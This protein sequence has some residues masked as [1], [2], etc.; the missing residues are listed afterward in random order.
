[1]DV[2]ECGH[3]ATWPAPARLCPHLVQ[4]RGSDHKPDFVRLLTGRGLEA[5]L[6]CRPCAD[7]P[8]PPILV[9][10]CGGCLEWVE[11]NG[12]CGRVDGAPEIRERPE[13]VDAA[14]EELVLPDELTGPVD[15]QP[16][17]AATGSRWVALSR[18]QQLFG[19][20][21]DTGQH[22]RLCKVPASLRM[23]GSDSA[24][25]ARSHATP[26]SLRLSSGG[27]L[28]A[29]VETYGPGG[30]V[31]DLATGQRTMGLERGSSYPK[32]QQFSCAFLRRGGRDVLVH[33]TDWN[34][35][36]AS[37]ARTGE[38]LTG[39]GAATSWTGEKERP[40]HYVD[41]FHSSLVPLPGGRWLAD[42]G[43]MW[44]PF[45]IVMTW[46]VDAWLDG[47]VWESE[48][49][50]TRREFCW[51]EY[52]WD[53]PLC[54][55]EETRLAV[56]GMGENEGAM[57]PGVRVFEVTTGAEVR[58]FPGPDGPLFAHGRWLLGAAPDGLGVWDPE[59]GERLAR[60]PGF[61]PT[62]HHPTVHELVAVHEDRLVRWRLPRS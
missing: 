10:V 62:R 60:V 18:E 1:M 14:L 61:T 34:R 28:A 4:A 53:A 19:L 3:A 29:V 51:R 49:G 55:L 45:G 57:I 52:L 24:Y 25:Q 48:D 40:P 32:V 38:L 8:Q 44:H 12:W 21:L 17:Q 23:T 6:A 41:Y 46:S 37:D 27:D 43:W 20:D 42:N 35:L 58:A 26:L 54:W 13:P 22:R 9:R 5:D 7:G 31:V 30:V 33:A 2:H 11:H 47:N 15:L 16:V 36:D 56:W 59:S 50:P 39:R